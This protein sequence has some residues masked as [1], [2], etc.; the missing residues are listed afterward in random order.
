MA[1]TTYDPNRIPQGETYLENGFTQD[2]LGVQF[3]LQVGVPVQTIY[4]FDVVPAA[5]SATCVSS[6]NTWRS[7]GQPL[8]TNVQGTEPNVLAR[9]ILIN[10][11]QGMQFDCERCITITIGGGSLIS[12]FTVTVSGYDYLLNPITFSA[13]YTNSMTSAVI[14]QP[15]NIVTSIV[16]TN[17]N[18]SGSGGVQ[19]VSFGNSDVIGLP[20]LLTSKSYVLDASWKGV[21]LPL[22]AITTGNDWRITNPGMNTLPV[23][24]SVTLPSDAN[25]TSL[26]TCCY[27]VYGNDSELSAEMDNLNQSSLKIASIQSSTSGQPVMPDLTPHDLV[28]AT[29][30]ASNSFM[31]NYNQIKNS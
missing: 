21:D 11:V 10:G 8:N 3:P 20:Y 27:Y 14:P 16:C 5:F 2:V 4:M 12:D 30:P 9:P 13:S 23:R 17:F 15:I 25:N 19:T 7:G 22:T 29:Y 6:A 26:M 1:L 18:S 31:Y 24:G 28:G